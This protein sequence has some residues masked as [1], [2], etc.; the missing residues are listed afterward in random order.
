MAASAT[1][2]VAPHLAGQLESKLE[3]FVGVCGL[4]R[5]EGLV[6]AWAWLVLMPAV[7]PIWSSVEESEPSGSRPGTRAGLGDHL[8]CLC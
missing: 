3:R 7:L 1:R 4:G 6:T 2:R 5:E 8:V